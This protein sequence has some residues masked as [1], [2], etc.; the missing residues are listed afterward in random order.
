MKIYSKIL[1]KVI[2]ALFV[3]LLFNSC[4]TEEFSEIDQQNGIERVQPEEA[5]PGIIG[6]EVEVELFGEPATMAEINKTIVFEGDILIPYENE[7]DTKL[8][9]LT[10]RRWTNNTVYYEIQSS[11]TNQARVTNAIA[12]WEANTALRFVKRTTQSNYI[13]F[14]TSTGCSSYVGMIGGRQVINLAPGCS[15]GNTIHEIGHAVG[16][17][18]EQSRADRDEYVRILFEN[19]ITGR[20]GNF[21]TYIANGQSG[22]D[23][24]STLDFGSIMMYGPTFFSKNGSPTITKLDGST[25]SIQRTSLSVN[26]IEGINKMYPS[27]TSGTVTLKGNNGQYVSSENGVKSMNC[28]RSAANSWETFTIIDEGGGT[29]SI[30]GNNGKYVSSEN[31]TKP[32]NCNRT[33]PGS[34]AK[35]TLVSRGGNKYAI[36]ANINGKYISSENG[37]K[38]MTCNRT[39]IGAWEEFTITGL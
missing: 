11:L 19:I 5:F 9:G 10:G 29:V 18:H 12:H 16:I 6:N 26:D 21:R 24:T 33:T 20:E 22:E 32:I 27:S 13:Y 36:R 38:E 15:T 35:F 25:Y 37:T 1:Q 17:F 7:G 31:G 34:W 28:N 8:A 4:V 39:S 30:R 23:Y 3:C 2:C 14:Q